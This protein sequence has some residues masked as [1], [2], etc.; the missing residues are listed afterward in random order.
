MKLSIEKVIYGGQ[1]LARIP[2]SHA[3]E[4][5]KR[6]FVPFTL[7]GEIVDVRLE[8]DTRGYAVGHLLQVETASP[9]RVQPAC[10]Y[11][12]RCG[13]C[14]LQHAID[15]AQ[16]E[17]KHSI[18]RET[19]E[20]A[21]I[22]SIPKISTLYGQPFAYRNRVRLHLQT[23]P[24][25][26][27]GYHEQNTNTLISIEQCPIAMPPLERCIHALRKLGAAGTIPHGIDEI[28]LF[29]NASGTEILLSAFTSR[30]DDS[31]FA[32][33]ETFFS[34]LAAQIPELSGAALF[35]IPKD[36]N[37]APA[38]E[39]LLRWKAQ[40]LLYTVGAHTYR[41]SI[42][43]FFQIHHS[44]L[45]SFVSLVTENQSGQQAWDLYAGVGLFSRVLAE[46]FSHVTAVEISPA[47]V[48]DLHHNLAHLPATIFRGTT[49]D[50]L[51]HAL[52]QRTVSPDLV[53]L[54]PPRAGLGNIG[55]NLLA[56]CR[57]RRI[58]Y[59]SCDP[60]TLSRDLK[61]LIESGY[62]LDRLHMVDM[63]PQTSHQETVAALT[64]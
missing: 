8:E 46:N 7:S 58:V 64:R 56:R 59:V 31:L 45:E 3:K 53:V 29:T 32:S 19:L 23:Q 50:F 48:E 34:A 22:Q 9:L 27:I 41:V 21:N 24:Y 49:E 17:I 62:R 40:S 36:R 26:S 2:A 51:R 18:L 4:A 25:F 38:R 61:A 28:E 35:L 6:I 43:A 30:Q 60:V 44:L 33:C 57:P 55:V 12:T 20:R 11:F 15:T 1:G 47:A 37:V 39:A 14:Q 42:G 54:D 5:G 10:P 13:G 63:F 16:V 52:E